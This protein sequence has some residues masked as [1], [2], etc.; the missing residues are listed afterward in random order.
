MR[1]EFTLIATFCC[2]LGLYLGAKLGYL[3]GNFALLALIGWALLMRS[4]AQPAAQRA[5]VELAQREDQ[6]LEGEG[7]HPPA[8]LTNGKAK[9]L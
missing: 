1:Q 8:A 3:N 6:A 7:A 2:G 5:G 4:M 9:A